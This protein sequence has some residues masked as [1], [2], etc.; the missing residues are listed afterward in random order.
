MSRQVHVNELALI[1]VLGLQARSRISFHESWGS[2]TAGGKFRIWRLNCGVAGC[3][4]RKAWPRAP[5][6]KL[7]SSF[8][9]RWCRKRFCSKT[10]LNQRGVGRTTYLLQRAGRWG[11]RF[12]LPP[13]SQPFAQPLFRAGWNLVF[14]DDCCGRLAMSYNYT[15][16]Q[17]K[18][19]AQLQRTYMV[20]RWQVGVFMTWTSNRMR[21]CGQTRLDPGNW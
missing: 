1:L 12:P 2:M 10:T 21:S 20:F 11:G 14:G 6:S 3:G 9:Q 8:F 17:D 7:N 16:S 19:T 4:C 15:I 5:Q 18:L 13:C